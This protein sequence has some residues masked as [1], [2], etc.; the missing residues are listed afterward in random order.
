[1]RYFLDNG[2]AIV[3]T[4]ISEIQAKLIEIEK[5]NRIVQKYAKL[6]YECGN[7]NHKKDEILALVDT[8]IRDVLEEISRE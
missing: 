5:D 7:K 4:T 8:T 3:A 2:V 6:A 1:M